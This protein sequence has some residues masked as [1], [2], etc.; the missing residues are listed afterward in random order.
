MIDSS[1]ISISFLMYIPIQCK[2]GTG[3][4][5]NHPNPHAVGQ[6]LVVGQGGRL[7]MLKTGAGGSVWWHEQSFTGRPENKM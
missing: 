4:R 5:R 1:K 6:S 7:S 2:S 3:L